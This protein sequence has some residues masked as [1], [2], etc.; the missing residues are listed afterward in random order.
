MQPHPPPCFAGL[1]PPV[2]TAAALARAASPHRV[3]RASGASTPPAG[4][5]VAAQLRELTAGT[6]RG[7]AT[8][9]RARAAVLALVSELERAGGRAGRGA[10]ATPDGMRALDGR[11]ELVYQQPGAGAAV[12][13]EGVEVQAGRL[14]EASIYATDG[15]DGARGSVWQNVDVERGVLENR[16]E[17]AWF[18]FRVEAA[19]AVAPG[20]ESVVEVAFERARFRLWRLP[21]VSVPISWLG[22]RGTLD[23]TYVDESVRVGRGDK[24]TLFVLVRP[25]A[26]RGEQ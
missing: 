8:G 23:C 22:G 16:A 1:A 3:P 10:L 25:D 24:G 17:G 26:G 9:A 4:P 11:W 14:Q 6:R 20:S 21:E 15:E 19:F 12:A 2:H 13:P 5:S 7:A 18:C